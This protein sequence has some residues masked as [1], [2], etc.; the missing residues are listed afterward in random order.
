MMTKKEIISGLVKLLPG[1]QKVILRY[2]GSGDSFDSFN[3][4]AVLDDQGVNIEDLE[5]YNVETDVINH[6]GDYMFDTIFPSAECEP[7]FNDEGSSG[8]ITFDLLNKVIILENT[9][10][11]DVTEY[12]DDEDEDYEYEERD[13]QCDPEVF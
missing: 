7:N 3:S 6:I 13:E 12:P 11:E 1:A 8:T 9:Y 2:E 10:W 4:I 5:T